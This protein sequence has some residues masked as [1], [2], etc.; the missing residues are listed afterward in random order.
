MQKQECT[1]GHME[2]IVCHTCYKTYELMELCK[3][4]HFVRKM[5]VTALVT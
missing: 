2:S 4:F 3:L 1:L 5:L